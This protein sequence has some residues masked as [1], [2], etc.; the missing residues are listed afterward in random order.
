MNC[1]DKFGAVIDGH[2]YERSAIRRWLVTK[3]KTTSPVTREPMDYSNCKTDEDL[4]R[5][6]QRYK[7]KIKTLSVFPPNDVAGS[8]NAQSTEIPKRYTDIFYQG[9]EYMEDPVLYLFD[10]FDSLIVRE[11]I[12]IQVRCTDAG[13]YVHTY[14][15]KNIE[16]WLKEKKVSPNNNQYLEMKDCHSDSALKLEIKAYRVRNGASH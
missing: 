1:Y 13:G 8:T 14:D 7:E 15:R 9:A 12:S 11:S 2:A 16:N 4:K 3:S 5:R 6:I 10:F